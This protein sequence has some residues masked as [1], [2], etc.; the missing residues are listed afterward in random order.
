MKQIFFLSL[1]FTLALAGCAQSGTSPEKQ[2]TDLKVGDRCEGCEAIYESP[3]PFEQLN[4]TDTL[5]DFHEPGT[6]LGVSGIIYRQDGKTPAANVVMY[7]YHT[8]QSGIYP[9]KGNEKGLAK[10]HGYLRGWVK[11]DA[12]G[13]Y[14]FYTLRPASYPNSSNPAHIHAII[15][16]PGKSEYWI[17]D[18]LFEDDPFLPKQPPA[19]YKPRA[20][21]GILKTYQKDGLLQATRLIYLGLNIPGYPMAGNPG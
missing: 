1:P 4:E 21:N 14:R 13:A 3:V 9:K 5:P 10:R 19:G 6:K 8:D 16:E 2:K 7:F 12:T 20:G 18:F 17:D 11:T 15:K